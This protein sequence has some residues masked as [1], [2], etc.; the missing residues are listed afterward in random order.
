MLDSKQR[1]QLKAI[2]SKTESIF[3][4]GKGGI[5][6]NLVKQLDDVIRVRELIKITVLD[7][8]DCDIK[9]TAREIAEKIGADVVQTIGRKIVL[10][11]ENPEKPVIS[12]EL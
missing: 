10:Y 11:R 7:N 5:T 9:E 12:N 8:S 2:A 1:A 3:Q 6:E 4:I